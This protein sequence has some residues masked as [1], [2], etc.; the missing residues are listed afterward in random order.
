[1]LLKLDEDA[2]TKMGL[3]FY[4]LNKSVKKPVYEYSIQN[5]VSFLNIDSKNII[6]RFFQV[7]LSNSYNQHT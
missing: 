7:F 5:Q 6:I 4:D 1:M 3:K 2:C